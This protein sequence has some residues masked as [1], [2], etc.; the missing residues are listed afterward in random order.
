MVLAACASLL[1][2]CGSSKA[3]SQKL[4]SSHLDGATAAQ[5][6][7]IRLGDLPAGFRSRAATAQA[8][9]LD[10]SQTL[11]EYHCEELAP[12]SQKATVTESTPDYTN[13]TGTT[14]LHETTAV[15]PTDVA[16][17][18]RLV[19]DRDSRYPSCKAAAFRSSLVASAPRGSRVG[20]VS[21]SLRDLPASLGDTGVEVAG[22]CQVELPGGVS[23]VATADLVVLV[24]E[25]FVVELAVDTDGPDLG[26]LLARLTTDL[27]HRL[28][29]VL[30]EPAPRH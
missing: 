26:S 14:E 30:P 12:P 5:F 8:S 28:S 15:F 6:V 13:S 27:A 7:S 3:S 9:S 2:G 19:L 23:E 17:S 20:S 16:A 29:Q 11:A 25:H 24:R 10:A 1:A 21:V 4:A 18:A 22:I